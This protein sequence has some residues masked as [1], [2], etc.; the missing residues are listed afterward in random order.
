MRVRASFTWGVS[1]RTQVQRDQAYPDRRNA[2][3]Q[4]VVGSEE[5]RIDRYRE[6]TCRHADFA[7]LPSILSCRRGDLD[8]GYGRAEPIERHEAESMIRMGTLMASTAG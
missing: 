5:R 3:D 4:R 1:G 6:L 7:I 2:G 8:P